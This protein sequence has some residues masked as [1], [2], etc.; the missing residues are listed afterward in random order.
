MKKLGIIIGIV[1]GILVVFG[2]V[3]VVLY[4]RAK[5]HDKK[6]VK[7]NPNHEEEVYEP[8]YHPEV[9]IFEDDKKKSSNKLKDADHVEDERNSSEEKIQTEPDLTENENNDPNG[10]SMMK[11][12]EAQS[13]LAHE[14]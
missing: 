13:P 11:G 5:R 9:N 8:Q 12:A 7:T 1:V 4:R 6:S 2:I 14:T 3:A 10:R